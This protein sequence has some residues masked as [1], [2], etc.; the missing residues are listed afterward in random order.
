MPV[1]VVREISDASVKLDCQLLVRISPSLVIVE[2]AVDALIL[3]Q[4]VNGFRYVGGGVE[5]DIILPVKVGHGRAVPRAE[6]E[7]R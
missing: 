4:H 3:M 6:R 5:N 2:Q 1:I 7:E